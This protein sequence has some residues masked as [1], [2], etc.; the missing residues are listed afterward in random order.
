[1]PHSRVR[2][3]A[4][5]VL[6]GLVLLASAALHESPN[7]AVNQ[8][9][10]WL[11]T[12]VGIA[13]LWLLG[14]RACW[15]IPLVTFAQRL[16]LGYEVLVG[17][18][19][20]A[21]S[22]A[23]ALLG[24]FLLRRLGFRASLE[25]LADVAVLLATA[26]VAPLGSIFFSWIGRSFVWP[27]P[28]MPFYSGWDG[29]WR[30]NA[31]G[32]LAVVPVVTHWATL[33]RRDVTPRFLLATVA[34]IIG[35]PAMLGGFMG[36]V[37]SGITGVMS[38]YL[39][40]VFMLY[41]AVRFGVRGATLAGALAA[42]TV[43]FVTTRGVGPFLDLP[44]EQRH[45]AI[46]LFELAFVAVPAAFAA[47]VAERQAALERGLRSEELLASINRNVNEGLFRTGY[48]A[49]VVYANLA[50]AQ[51][52]G[53]A[54]PAE[55]VGVPLTDAVADPARLEQLRA[56]IEAEGRWVNEEV[57]FRRRDGS[58]FWGLLS[59]TAARDGLGR[60]VQVDGV[61]AD[62]TERKQL[63]EQFR[64]S[65]K[66]EAVGKLAG[67]VAHDFNNLLT[68][69]IGHAE[70]LRA[71]AGAGSLAAGN[72]ER[73][74]DAAQRASGLTR[75][76]LAYSRQQVLAPRV[77][78]L[79]EVVRHMGEMVRRLI[80]EDVSLEVTAPETPCWVRV[81]RSQIEQVLL[82][83][84]V[85]ARDAMPVGGSL[86]ITL[87][88]RDPEPGAA[89][90]S[91]VVTV[92]DTGTGMPA[93]VQA[94]AFDPFFTTKP[95]GKGTGLGLSTVH[96]IVHQSGGSVWLESAPGAGTTVWIALPEVRAPEREAV[97]EP[98]PLAAVSVST[99]LVVEDEPA[100]RELVRH[101]LER[102]GH[103][104]LAAVDGLDAIAL[105]RAHAGPIDVVVSDVVMPRMSGREMAAVLLQA[106]PDLRFLFIS[107]Y[108]DDAGNPRDFVGAAGDFLAKPF[109]PAALVERVQSLLGARANRT[110]P[111]PGA[112]G[113]AAS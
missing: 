57:R 76:L 58:H 18:P 81:D 110:V 51:M 95:A 31:L 36:L 47:L 104:V 92:R 38:V 19:A 41:A 65:Q 82:N 39:L 94:R 112:A 78:D 27:N 99:V 20:A 101:A 80:G 89:A 64:Q 108:P 5:H 113:P 59:A 16:A 17:V 12:G 73:V 45:V 7:A 69:I 93:E 14:A 71:Q 24:L 96:G 109:T 9:I 49:T 50:L 21:G 37:P 60:V 53:H 40:L 25:R 84:V 42:I 70:L 107:G 97:V 6:F 56:T 61:I 83:L 15:V 10:V 75:Q 67:G 68:V 79:G 54:E 88:R 72:A 86:A 28:D 11:P 106:R 111:R 1:M 8:A 13:G 105:A 35:V 46:Q 77:L 44:R 30:M 62:V 52:L 90:G 33:P 2:A 74:L 22:T 85:N 32:V 100:V 48:G 102:A 91:V 29:W 4:S 66:M 3:L 23:E 34:A 63:E 98:T 103:R 87:V 26:A 43:A 55:L